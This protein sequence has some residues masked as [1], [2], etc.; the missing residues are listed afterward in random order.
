MGIATENRKR[1]WNCPVAAA[2]QTFEMDVASEIFRWRDRSF[3]SSRR[4]PRPESRGNG[5]PFRSIV[6]ATKGSSRNRCESRFRQV[7]VWPKCV[8]KKM[9]RIFP[10]GELINNR[11]DINGTASIRVAQ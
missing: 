11:K 9:K 2:G 3:L 10:G 6:T 5:D 4:T 1:S 8:H 7:V